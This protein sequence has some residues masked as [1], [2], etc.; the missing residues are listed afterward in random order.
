MRSSG[1]SFLPKLIRIHPAC[2]SC[3]VWTD[4]R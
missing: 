4:R 3:N 1:I 2:S